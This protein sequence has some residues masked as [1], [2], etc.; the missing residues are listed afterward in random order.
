MNKKKYLR[1]LPLYICITAAVVFL[2]VWCAALIRCEVLTHR[3]AD[4]FAHAHESNTML[5]KIAYFK[6]LH[7][8]GE[9][10]EVYYV[11]EGNTVGSV[12]EFQKTDE[13]WEEVSWRTVWSKNGSASDVVWP[14][15]WQFFITGA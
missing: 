2:I 8:E 6:V 11:S 15:W 12:L 9:T 7:C 3:Y 5:G 13:G 1:R 4:D 14:Y 10:A